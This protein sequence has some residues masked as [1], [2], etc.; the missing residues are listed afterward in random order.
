MNG[1][2]SG[3]AILALLAFG[4]SLPLRD[5]PARPDAAEIPAAPLGPHCDKTGI[6]WVLPHSAALEKAKRTG[7]LLMIKP[8]AGATFA[9]GGW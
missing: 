7:R 6:E 5:A 8:I 3:G 4:C 1:R 9:D 2:M